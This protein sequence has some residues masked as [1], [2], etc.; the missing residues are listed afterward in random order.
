MGKGLKERV[1]D[2]ERQL[3]LAALQRARGVQAHAAK[4]LGISERVLRYKMKKYELQI[5]TKLS[6]RDRIVELVIPSVKQ[7]VS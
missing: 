2:L 6:G 7:K 4:V 1:E 3:I 5:Q